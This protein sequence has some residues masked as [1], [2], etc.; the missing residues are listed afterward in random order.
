[1]SE[2]LSPA[3]RPES[4]GDARSPCQQQ[5]GV[6]GYREYY[7]ADDRNR[8]GVACL[9]GTSLKPLGHIRV[10]QFHGVPS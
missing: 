5:R 7:R 2:D 10:C 9:E 6:A 8:T 3:R 1:M 4:P